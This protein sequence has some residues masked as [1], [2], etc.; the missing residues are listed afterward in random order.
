MTGSTFSR[1]EK[2]FNSDTEERILSPV[3][4]INLRASAEEYCKPSR[5]CYFVSTEISK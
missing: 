3:L 2:V 1:E 5:A 4:L